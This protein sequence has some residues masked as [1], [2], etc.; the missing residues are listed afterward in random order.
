MHAGIEATQR[1]AVISKAAGAVVTEN[2]V[3]EQPNAEQFTGLPESCAQRSIF[4]ARCGIPGWV[5]GC[6]DD[7]TG[8]EE[9][10]RF[11]HFARMHD[12]ECERANRNDVDADDR[13]FG[14]K[15]TDDE[16][17]AIESDKAWTQRGGRGSGITEHYPEACVTAVRHDADFVT[18]NDAGAA[19]PLSDCLAMWH[20]LDV[21]P[22]GALEERGASVQVNGS[23]ENSRRSGSG[24]AQRRP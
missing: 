20:L 23:D 24:R 11:E 16:L 18:W 12:A 5:I 19:T 13:V 7:C 8:V 17:L 3:V 10:R 22:T 2:E 6:G 14:I 21:E 9:N 4:D 1:P 15:T